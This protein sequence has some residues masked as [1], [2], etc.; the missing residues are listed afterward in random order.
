MIHVSRDTIPL[1]KT[2]FTGN[3]A[4]NFYRQKYGFKQ[5]RTKLA[6]NMLKKDRK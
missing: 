1:R 2:S 6:E 5:R 4:I 3:G